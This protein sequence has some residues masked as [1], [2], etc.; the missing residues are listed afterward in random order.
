MEDGW[1]KGVLMF[2][3]RRKR[4]KKKKVLAVVENCG[5]KLQRRDITEESY[6]SDPTQFSEIVPG[7]L[8]EGEEY[9]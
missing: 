5:R 3:S 8:F 6:H 1:V 9:I 4:L 2:G 7:T